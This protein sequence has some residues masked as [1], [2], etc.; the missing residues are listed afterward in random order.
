[1]KEADRIRPHHTAPHRTAQH[2]TAHHIRYQRNALHC[3]T[4][5][6]RLCRTP[7]H[8]NPPNPYPQHPAPPYGPS[9]LLHSSAHNPTQFHPLR[10]ILHSLCCTALCCTALHCTWFTRLIDC[11]G[12]EC[13]TERPAS[14]TRSPNRWRSPI[15][16]SFVILTC[17]SRRRGSRTTLPFSLE[18]NA[19]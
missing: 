1:M 8:F 3:T 12:T 16:L 18:A 11:T 6:T 4:L 5:S 13:K 9:T 7:S 14:R 10:S 17:T 2:R 15:T 19:A